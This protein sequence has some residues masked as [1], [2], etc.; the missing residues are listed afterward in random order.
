[1]IQNGKV[2]G[3]AY[4]LTDDQGAVVDASD[5]KDPFFYLHGA[6]QIVPGLENALVGLKQGD[7]K[8]VQV[9][10]EEG[11]GETNPSLVMTVQRSQFPAGS[12]LEE[13][14]QFQAESPEGQ[15]MVFTIAGVEG[16]DITI[17][18]NHP[19]AGKTLHFAIEVLS[20]RDATEEEKTHG[21]AHGPGGHHH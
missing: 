15:A 11:Y 6:S 2:V 19:M 3:L 12:E 16:D 18:G 7:K 1:M 17:D 8:K 9:S 20:V 21:H 10:P 5:A 4:Q 13:G 14:M